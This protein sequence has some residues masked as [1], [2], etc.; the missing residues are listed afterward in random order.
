VIDVT[1]ARKLRSSSPPARTVS[2]L[3]ERVDQSS[4]AALH[5]LMK[6]RTSG[7]WISDV[8]EYW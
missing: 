1:A 5:A 8:N 6:V 3:T 2:L 7:G 4:A